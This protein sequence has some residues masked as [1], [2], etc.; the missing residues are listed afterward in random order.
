MSLFRFV[1]IAAFFSVAF[2]GAAD[3]KPVPLAGGANSSFADE[4]PNDRK[5]GWLDLGSDDLR[6]IPAGKNVWGNVPFQILDDK[7]TKGKSCIV[8]SAAKSRSYLPAKAELKLAAPQK[9]KVLYL[10]HGGAMLNPKQNLLGRLTV[11]YEDGSAKEFRIRTGRD[12]NDWC[13]NSSLSNAA[14]VWSVYNNNSQ[15]SV[16]AS[17][18]AL[19][20]KN[21]SSILFS[22]GDDGVWM[23]AAVSLGDDVKVKPIQ[24]VWSHRKDYPAP[25]PADAEKLA[26]VPRNGIPKNI[27]LIIGDGMGQG[28]VKYT[29]LYAHGAPQSLFMEQLPVRGM[30]YTFS[31]NR[32]V[33]DSAASGTALSS[34][35]K[36]NNGM[37]GMTPKKMRIRSFAEEARDSGRRVGVL[38]TDALTGATPAAQFAHVPSRGMA[39]EIAE[40][41]VKCG[42]HILIGSNPNAFLPEKRK[43]KRNLIME[44]KNKGY[45]QITDFGSFRKAE[46]K[47]LFGFVSGWQEN[48]GLLSFF[49]AEA[50]RRLEND[51]GFF[52]MV[53]GSYPDYGG[54]GNNPDLTL[55]GVLMVD[56]TVK[57]AVE[58]ASKRDDTLVVVTADHETGGIF[59]APNPANPRQPIIGYTTK[60]HTGAPVDIFAYGPGA[61]N[62][63][64]LLDNTEIPAVFAKLWKLPLN[65]PVK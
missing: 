61:E 48:T 60:S 32:D 28:A 11:K 53:E 43:D 14:R 37:V 58:F 8:L 49:A 31:A 39:F 17:K 64:K 29:G 45:Q 35:Y 47:P 20:A 15:V 23:I 3:I 10:L 46:D 12:V 36:T 25:A 56:F 59:C 63:M 33:T 2:A 5:G 26:A 44:F 62:F 6:S 7:E 16:Y 51:K 13:A 19:E 42:Y 24:E 30:A 40:Y 50:F 9:G 1:L 38:T 4:M 55:N 27:I 41:A 52:I 54:H 57:A 18:F 21:I 22:S 34:G 65:V